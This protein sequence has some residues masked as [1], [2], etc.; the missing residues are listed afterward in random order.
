MQKIIFLECAGL[1]LTDWRDQFSRPEIENDPN[2]AATRE[3]HNLNHFYYYV[4]RIYYSY[5]TTAKKK[6]TNITRF[7]QNYLKA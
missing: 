3:M 7:N 5:S 1:A 6:Y 4:L 2:K